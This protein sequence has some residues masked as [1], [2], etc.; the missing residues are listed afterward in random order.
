MKH[1]A[2]RW[3]TVRAGL[4]HFFRLAEWQWMLGWAVVA[5]VLGALATEA[6]RWALLGQSGSLV[7][8]RGERLPVIESAEDPRLLGVVNKSA[9]L[10]TYARLSARFLGRVIR[11]AQTYHAPTVICLFL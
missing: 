6:F 7:A 9:L 4:Q 10:A 5:G 1:L 3:L 8:H 2:F 11:Q